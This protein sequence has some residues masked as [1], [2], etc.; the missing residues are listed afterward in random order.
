MS[1][2]AER[3]AVPLRIVVE[4]PLPGVTLKLQRGATGKGELVP[5]VAARAEALVF[6]CDVSVAGTLA[7]G[8]PRLLGPFVQGPPDGRFVYLCVGQ[9]AGQRDSPF[10][11]RIKVPLGAL[12][13]GLVNSLPP[14]A[15]LEARIGGRGRNGGPAYAT[16]PLLAPWRAVP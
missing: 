12:T 9:G 10:N 8:R 6:E 7:D 5:P 14:G 16:V 15:R 3:I 4:N 2:R 13:H 11:G 1:P